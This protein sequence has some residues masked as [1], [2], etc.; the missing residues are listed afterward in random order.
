MTYSKQVAVTNAVT[1]GRVHQA[2]GRMP[3]QRS[4]FQVESE[5]SCVGGKRFPGLFHHQ[6]PEWETN[7]SL[8]WKHFCC[9]MSHMLDWDILSPWEQ[10]TSSQRLCLILMDTNGGL[11]TWKRWSKVIRKSWISSLQFPPADDI[12]WLKRV[13]LFSLH[14]YSFWP[15]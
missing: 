5:V 6:R 2:V 3:P 11:P 7:H 12:L 8:K 9:T 13:H 1:R 4:W 14:L 10:A 15:F